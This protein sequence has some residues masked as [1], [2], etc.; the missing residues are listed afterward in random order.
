MADPRP[1]EIPHDIVK[2]FLQNRPQNHGVWNPTLPSQV[3]GD[4]AEFRQIEWHFHES[5]PFDAEPTEWGAREPPKIPNGSAEILPRS[6]PRNHGGAK[7]HP[8]SPIKRKFA[9]FRQAGRNSHESRNFTADT[10]GRR[11][12]EPPKF[13]MIPWRYFYANDQRITGR[14]IPTFRPKYVAISLNFAGSGGIPTESRPRRC[15]AG[16][17]AD[18]R[19]AECR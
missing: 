6:L 15:R 16:R 7:S 14:A 1:A 11:A 17:M 3:I 19:S 5:R 9:E 12:R 18:P 2:I 8:F 13:P 4:F 10:A